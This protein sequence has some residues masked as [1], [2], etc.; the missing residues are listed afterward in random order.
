MGR[1]GK[2]D[3]VSALIGFL[4]SEGGGYITTGV[5]TYGVGHRDAQ[6]ILNESADVGLIGDRLG[7]PLGDD[8]QRRELG[9]LRSDNA[10]GI[11]GKVPALPAPL[12]L[13]GGGAA[14]PKRH[15][16]SAGGRFTFAGPFTTSPSA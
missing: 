13:W 14:A 8:V 1:Y 5:L 16:P 9:A 10:V 15:S 12:P 2:T 3:E 4:A 7:S 6:T 11:C